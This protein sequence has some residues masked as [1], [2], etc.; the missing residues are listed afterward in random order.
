[1]GNDDVRKL[2]AGLEREQVVV[3]NSSKQAGADPRRRRILLTV[4]GVCALIALSLAMF[5]GKMLTPRVLSKQDLALQGAYVFD[6]PRIIKPFSLLDQNAEP[7]TLERLQGRWSLLFFGY[8]YCPDICPTTLADLKKF[9][10]ML[11]DADL[12]DDVQIILVSVDPARDTPEQ[13]AR[14]LAYFDP[15]FIGV[16]GEFLDVHAF[17]ANVNAAFTKVLSPG[18]A[19]YLVDHTSN[20]VLVNPYGHYHGFFKPQATL[21]DGQFDPG[22]LK[23]TFQSIDKSFEGE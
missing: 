11:A 18:N 3:K 20:I 22:K 7:F 23:V 16:T 17:A 21:T 4:T 15:E 1:M 10:A 2:S 6:N 5:V 12:N 8:T 13:L 9:K 19:S 14:Y